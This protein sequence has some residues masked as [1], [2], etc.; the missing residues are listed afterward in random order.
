MDGRRPLWRTRQKYTDWRELAGGIIIDA[1]TTAPTKATTTV[2]DQ[3]WYRRLGDTMEI[4]ASYSHIDN[5]GTASGSGIYL[6][7]VPKGLTIDSAK[8]R[9]TTTLAGSICGHGLGKGAIAGEFPA[10]ARV[11]PFD[12]TH[13]AMAIAPSAIAA[14]GGTIT[15]VSSSY[16]PMSSAEV[17][18]YFL[19]TVPI[20]Q[21]DKFGGRGG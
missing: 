19:A 1:V 13:L 17:F 18:Y 16:Q 12:T 21:W 4:K 14:V 6:F 2:R 3:A 10:S 7:R 20:L 5:T 9:I 15:T 8:I 11:W